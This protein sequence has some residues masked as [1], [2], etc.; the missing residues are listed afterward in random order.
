MP[1]PEFITNPPDGFSILSIVR[2]F[3]LTFLGAY[4]ALQ[5]P[6]LLRGKYYKQAAYAIAISLIIQFIITIPLW[7][8]KLVISVFVW[9]FSRS[10]DS[11]WSE[12]ATSV[13]NR[14]D[15]IESHVINLSGLLIGLMRYL[16]PEMDE[17]FMESL[18]FIDQVYFRMHPTQAVLPETTTTETAKEID[19]SAVTSSRYYAPLSLYST[20]SAR[21]LSAARASSAGAVGDREYVPMQNNAAKFVSRYFRRSI[22]S[23]AIYF[24]SLIPYVGKIVLQV[25]SFYSFRKTV[26]VVPAVV[27][28]GTAALVPK[29]WLTIF[30]A[31]YWGSRSLTRELLIPYFA[32]IPFTPK[33][34]D[35]WYRAREGVLFGFGFGF[36]FIL[37]IPFVGVLLYGIAEASTAYLVTKISDP[38]PPP[39]RVLDWTETH[40]EWSRRKRMLDGEILQG[41]GFA[42]IVYPGASLPGGFTKEEKKTK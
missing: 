12:R 9:I 35:A 8:V 4:R 18:R 15:F 24:L 13:V 33:Q 31:A 38:P 3:Q 40:T 14:I 30:L 19:A 26:G 22:L 7:I 17:M 39:T 1:S 23:V 21:M 5:N 10:G 25:I 37:K 41:E 27:V 20:S 6:D 16:R 2:G 42:P 28:F 11:E 32:R 34:R 36:Y 29:K